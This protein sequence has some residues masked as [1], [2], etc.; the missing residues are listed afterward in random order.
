MAKTSKLTYQG[1]VTER[2][3]LP[4]ALSTLPKPHTGIVGALEDREP[5]SNP[6]TNSLCTPSPP[7]HRAPT[8][9]HKVCIE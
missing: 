5:M 3:E 7:P 6:N 2:V 4:E 1:D 8:C 9:G